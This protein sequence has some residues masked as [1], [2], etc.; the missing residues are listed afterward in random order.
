MKHYLFSFNFEKHTMNSYITKFLKEKNIDY[1]Y[2]YQQI[3]ADI[4]RCNEYYKI[5]LIDMP[6]TKKEIYYNDSYILSNHKNIAS[7]ENA[8][9]VNEYENT[10]VIKAIFKNN[11]IVT[12]I[13]GTYENIRKHYLGSIFNLGSVNDDL[14]ECIDVEFLETIK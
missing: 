1:F 3:Y 13:N 5:E 11:E 7:K 14:Q 2:H 6:G 12:R 10:Y 4:F 9:N 8:I